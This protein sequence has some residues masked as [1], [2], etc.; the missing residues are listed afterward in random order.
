MWF[1]T[2]FWNLSSEPWVWWRDPPQA[3][4]ETQGKSPQWGLKKGFWSCGLGRLP[5]RRLAQSPQLLLELDSRT[6][7]PA[8]G[9]PVGGW[10]NSPRRLCWWGEW[11]AS[12]LLL[13]FAMVGGVL[14]AHRPHHHADRSWWSVQGRGWW[15]VLNTNRN[16]QLFHQPCSPFLLCPY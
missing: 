2:I 6:Y 14:W 5:V 15:E 9:V 12:L 10:V 16:S 7:H 3:S 13:T 11:V 8:L 4:E 1:L